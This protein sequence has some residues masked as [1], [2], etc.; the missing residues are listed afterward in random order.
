MFNRN[1]KPKTFK[2]AIA[3]SLTFSA[4]CLGGL[5]F[6]FLAVHWLTGGVGNMT[7]QPNHEGSSAARPLSPGSPEYVLK[8]HQADCWTGNQE[9]KADLPGAAIIQWEKNG[10]VQYTTVHWKVSAAF[11]EALASI[12]YGDKVSHK[13]DVIAL[14]K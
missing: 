11:N 5:V 14:C 2:Q 1:R 9:K 4:M 6:G 3:G 13:L 12:G 8:Q 7:M 10:M